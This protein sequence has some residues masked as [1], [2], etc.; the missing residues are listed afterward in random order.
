MHPNA[1]LLAGFY[2]AFAAKDGAAMA[3]AYHPEAQFSDPVFTD[4]RGPEVGA[5]WKMLC[6]RATD[7]K[8]E[9]RDIAATEGSGSAHWEAWYTFTKTG[10]PV[11]NVIDAAF[12]FKDGRIFLHRDSFDFWR[13]SRMALGPA[14]MLLGWTPVLRNAVRKEARAGL[15]KFMARSAA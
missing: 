11:H 13:W 6:S 2:A 7:L 15:A 12:E 14:G 5:M 9:A 3:S 1:E 8:V 10:R 4:L